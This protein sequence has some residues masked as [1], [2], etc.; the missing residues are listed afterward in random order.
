MDKII[1]TIEEKVVS[2][3]QMMLENIERLKALS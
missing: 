3:N 2:E 1:D